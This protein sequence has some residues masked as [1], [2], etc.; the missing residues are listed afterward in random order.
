MS[1]ERLSHLAGRLARLAALPNDL[2]DNLGELTAVTSDLACMSLTPI[3]VPDEP[4]RQTMFD[5]PVLAVQIAAVLTVRLGGAISITQ[6]DLNSL[7][8]FSA[9]ESFS[10]DTETFTLTV[11]P[12]EPAV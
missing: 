11:T 6:A 5:D 12:K 3:N 8:Q 7:D 10:A 2:L 1:K 4:R 9:E